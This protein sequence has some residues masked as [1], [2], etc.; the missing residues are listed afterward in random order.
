MPKG[1]WKYMGKKLKICVFYKQYICSVECATVCVKSEVIL[2]L[3]VDFLHSM[4]H[5]ALFYYFMGH[6]MLNEW[7]SSTA[8]VNSERIC[9]TYINLQANLISKWMLWRPKT[10]NN[11]SF[12]Y[13]IIRQKWAVCVKTLAEENKM[14]SKL[15]IWF[16]WVFFHPRV[17]GH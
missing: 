5:S 11:V 12:K 6:K 7:F 1:H 9:Y 17:S 10:C 3:V 2:L 15:K 16:G 14:S 4:V 13:K 8:C